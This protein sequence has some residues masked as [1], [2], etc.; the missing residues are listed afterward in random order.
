MRMIYTV[1]L[2]TADAS[3]PTFT[4]APAGCSL[5]AFRTLTVT[6]VTTAIRQLSYKQCA[7]N[8]FPTHLLKDKVD[9]LA[10]FIVVVVQHVA[11]LGHSDAPCPHL[12]ARLHRSAGG[13]SFSILAL[14]DPP[15]VGPAG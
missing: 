4:P 8:P 10:P 5:S 3:L 15:A 11:S 12:T 14:V 13:M 9:L 2:A 7:S 1:S 6:D